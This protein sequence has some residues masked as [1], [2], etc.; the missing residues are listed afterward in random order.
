MVLSDILYCQIFRLLF[1]LYISLVFINITIITY[2]ENKRLNV[3]EYD[4][5]TFL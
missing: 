5:C 1:S 4:A 2:E 3:N